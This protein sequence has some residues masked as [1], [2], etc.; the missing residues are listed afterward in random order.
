MNKELKKII[1]AIRSAAKENGVT[2]Q[3]VS[4]THVLSQPDVKEW[5]L[6]KFG[7]LSAIKTAHFPETEKALTEIKLQ[8]EV[9]SYVRKLE[10]QVVEF[11]LFEK[12]VTEDVVRA[13]SSLQIKKVEIPKAHISRHKPAMTLELMLSDIHYGKLT[14][15]DNPFNLSICRAR[16]RHVVE[17]LLREIEQH[18]Q[19]FNVERLILAVIGDII[20]SYTMHG[21]ESSIGCEFNNPKQVDEAIESLWFDVLVPLSKTGLKID[22]V[23][24]TG[25]HDRTE[26]KRTMNKPGVNQLTWIIYRGLERLA[27]TAGMKNV[28]FHIPEECFHVLD[29]YGAPCLYEHT[30]N[31]NS[32]ERKSLEGLIQKRSKQVG[33]QI[34]FLRG[35]HWHESINYDRGR[36]IINESVPGQDGYS[37]TMGF[38]SQA[39]QT[40]NFYIQTSV[41]KTP[42][43]KSFPVALDHIK[44][45]VKT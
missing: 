6:R 40:I 27:K 23:G 39:G 26:T 4:K 34:L 11:Q 35:G 32:P 16:I 3:Q 24:V 18:R 9:K 45:G 20:E 41:R 30:D 29:I 44:E 12:R 19:H 28:T 15:G 42:F 25:N 43:Y 5:E 2:P 13:I 21:L 38:N 33:K 7:G 1:K 17:V 10:K 22:F 31:T 14:G 36:I 8:S 37:E